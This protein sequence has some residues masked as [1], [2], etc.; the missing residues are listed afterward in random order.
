MTQVVVGIDNG[1]TG[2]LAV[3]VVCSERTSVDV[4]PTPTIATKSGKCRRT[5]LDKAGMRELLYSCGS[6]A[7][8]FIEHA[9]NMPKQGASSA[10]NYGTGYGL[11]RGI[12]VGLNLQYT[13][14]SPRVWQRVMLQGTPGSDTKA[15]S[16]IR[17]KELFRGVSLLPTDRSRKDSDGMAD[18]LLIAEYGRRE[19]GL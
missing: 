16:I 15:R 3:L 4:F 14:V 2:A 17:V 9:Q 13:K 7:H 19:L 18:A 10:F 1:T 5:V 8:V 12:C 6:D 11:W